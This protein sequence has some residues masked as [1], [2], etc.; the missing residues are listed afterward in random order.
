VITVEKDSVQVGHDIR[1]T[2][3]TKDAYG[4][5]LE[6]GGY[7]VAFYYEGGTSVGTFDPTNDKGDGRYETHYLGQTAGTWGQIRA[8]IDGV[9]VTTTPP[10]MRVWQ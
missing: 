7:T 10:P 8:T 1:V 2:L 5:A 6:S 9:L 3:Y 4:N